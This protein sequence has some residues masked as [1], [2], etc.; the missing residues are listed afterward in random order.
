MGWD[1]NSRSAISPL[2][3]PRPARM[4]TRFCRSGSCRLVVTE[5]RLAVMLADAGI[6]RYRKA[7]RAYLGPRELSRALL[8]FIRGA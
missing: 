5:N 1:K 8:A 4:T 2:A 6:S 7:A 3:M